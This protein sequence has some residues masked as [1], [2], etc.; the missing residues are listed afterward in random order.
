MAAGGDGP[1]PPVWVLHGQPDTSATWWST[2]AALR[3]AVVAV[4]RP[5]PTVRLPDRPGYGHNPEAATDYA[6]NVTWLRRELDRAGVDEVV[7]VG[8][9][10]GGGVALLAAAQDPRVVG[11]ALLASVGPD[12]LLPADRIFEVPGL[13]EP[14]AWIA[15]GPGATFWRN[16]L[17]R[18][19]GDRIAPADVPFAR[20]TAYANRRRPV[21]RS[22]S[23]EQRALLRELP[24]IVDALPRVTVPTLVVAGRGDH[25]IPAATPAGLVAALPDTERVDLDV[26]HDMNLTAP[27]VTGTT[28]ARWL[29]AQSW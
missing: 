5:A 8:H 13:G 17:R 2:R 9:S 27:D 3:A 10:W 4:G 1:V 19:V 23:V 14:M 12:C 6:G 24:D 25:V 20:S 28:V 11:V 21:W 29:L 18:R 15:L 22:F 7:L 26:G 16:Y